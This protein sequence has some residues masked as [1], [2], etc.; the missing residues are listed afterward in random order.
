MIKEVKCSE[1]KHLRRIRSNS[2]NVID[3]PAFMPTR[4]T[5]GGDPDDNLG[6]AWRDYGGLIC[7]HPIC[8][9]EEITSDPVNGRSTYRI[10]TTG[11]GILNWK[12]DCS[13]FEPRT[14][15]FKSHSGWLKRLFGGE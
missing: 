9:K 10:R 7:G 1:C 5:R 6:T 4:W 14:S 13:Y 2:R 8:F 12:N 11:Q 3:F 15:W